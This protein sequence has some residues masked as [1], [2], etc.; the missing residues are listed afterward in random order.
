[1]GNAAANGAIVARY[2]V[3]KAPAGIKAEPGI[4]RRAAAA[5]LA[6]MGVKGQ[7]ALPALR[8]VL[9]DPDLELRRLASEAILAIEK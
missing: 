8:A 3:A 9:D 6:G 1:M 4:V 7:D 5:S 2:A